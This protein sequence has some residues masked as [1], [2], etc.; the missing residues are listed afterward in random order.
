MSVELLATRDEKQIWLQE[1]APP[2][3][4]EA[5]FPGE[6]YVCILFANDEAITPEEQARVSEQLV[7]TGCC[8][9]VCAGHQCSSWD[10]SVDLA[11]LATGEGEEK[12]VM[13]S[14]HENETVADV[15]FFGLLNTSFDEHDFT[16]Y[17]VLLVGPQAGLRDEVKRGIRKVWQVA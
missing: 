11:H 10:D 2:Y 5:P 16:R 14:W 4:L 15:I 13:T 6:L 1:L 3:R 9:A 12:F 17:L 7:G 8:Y